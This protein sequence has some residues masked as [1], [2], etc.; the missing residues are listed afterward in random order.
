MAEDK[1]SSR[2][3]YSGMGKTLLDLATLQ[4]RPNIRIDQIKYDILNPEE[5]TLSQ[6][7]RLQ[8]LGGKVYELSNKPALS[9][10]DQSD[11]SKAIN[12]LFEMIAFSVPDDVCMRLGEGQKLQV[13]EGF[14]QLPSA[15]KL[16][17]TQTEAEVNNSPS[18]PTGAR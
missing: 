2:K 17:A 9:E 1:N 18:Q 13:I 3:P 12:L 7:H 15:Q 6:L 4:D 8:Y 16:M 10:I 5:I 11:C 14:T